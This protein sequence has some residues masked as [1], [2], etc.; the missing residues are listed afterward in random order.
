MVRQEFPAVR[1]IASAENLGYSRG[2]NQGLAA[3]NARY[4][5]LLNPDTEIR[6]GTLSE[7]VDL[8]DSRPSI[9]LAG[10][11]QV[12]AS[13]ELLPTI[14]RFP[15]AV[16]ALG[17]AL[18]SEQLGV[19]AS[20]L[21]ERELDPAPYGRDTACDWVSGSFMLVRA[22]AIASV[23]LLDERFFLFSEEPDLC[24]R[25]ARAGWEVRHLPVMTILHH[26]DKAPP[27]PRFEA[28]DAYSRKLYARKHF[29]A[30]HRGLYAAALA[31]RYGV[32]ALGDGDSAKARASR[33][34]LRVLLGLDPPPFEPP[35]PQAVTR[36]GR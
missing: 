24:L 12:D 22:E 1:L 23:G 30:P 3:V 27:R 17:N 10:V 34:A 25:L 29:A 32:R 15:N 7:L 2:N 11:R 28:Q 5:L 21:G 16:R 33:A 35:P 20:W 14:R 19:R 4:V 18:A 13:G 36:R 31:V 26:A 8:L 6:E 9:G